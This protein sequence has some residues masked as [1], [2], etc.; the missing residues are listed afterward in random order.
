MGVFAQSRTRRAFEKHLIG[1]SP[2]KNDEKNW[3]QYMEQHLAFPF[4][5]KTRGALFSESGVKV[6]VL[7]MEDILDEEYGQVVK[8][9]IKR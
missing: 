9:K 1:R 7:G 8:V 4:H 3:A 6:Q 2:E 5:A